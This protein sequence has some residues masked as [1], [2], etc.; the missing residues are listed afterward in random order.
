[1]RLVSDCW[2]SLCLGPG[3]TRLLDSKQQLKKLSCFDRQQAT[4]DTSQVIH[5]KYFDKLANGIAQCKIC[6]RMVGHMKN[7][8]LTHNPE[9]HQCP[10]CSSTLARRSTL[11]RHLRLKH[12]L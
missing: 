12:N 3:G 6:G 5:F 8:F 7:H 10:I 11:V 9:S 1:M 2:F 4:G